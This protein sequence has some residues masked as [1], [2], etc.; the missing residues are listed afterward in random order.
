MSR[1][2]TIGIDARFWGEGGPGRYVKAIVEHLEKLDSKNDYLVFLRKSGVDGYRPKS[3]NFKV[4]VADYKWYT[5]DEQLSFLFKLLRFRIDL[6]YVPHFNIPVL[7]PGKIVAAIPDIIMHTF[8]TEEATTLPKIYFKFKKLV[9]RLVVLWAVLRSERVV[10]PSQFTLGEFLRV[11]PWIKADKFVCAYEGVDDVFVSDNDADSYRVLQRYQ[12][13]RPFL[14]CVGSMYKHKNVDGL[15][16]GFKILIDEYGFDGQLV[17]VGKKDAFAEMV[18]K[19]VL[20][21]GLSMRVVVPSMIEYVKDADLAILRRFASLYVFPS[22]MEG[23]SLTPLE[24]QAAG[25]PCLISDISC[26]KEVYGDSVAYF[27]PN[28][29]GGMARAINDLLTDGRKKEVLVARGYENARR[30]DWDITARTTLE[31]FD[32]ALND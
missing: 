28:D 7:Y 10:V 16:D 13:R 25:L 1:I 20:A 18:Y 21:E 3:P 24:A 30:Y 12:I 19:R 26:H 9:Y 15:L 31:V 4:V 14:L 8:S 23:F 11:Y 6:L 29:C 17:I 22:F 2:K 32:R 27:D 5:F